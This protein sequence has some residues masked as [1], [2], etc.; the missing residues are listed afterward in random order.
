MKYYVS[1]KTDYRNCNRR[2]FTLNQQKR[3]HS[4]VYYMLRPYEKEHDVR[5]YN[6]IFQTTAFQRSLFGLGNGIMIKESGNGKLNTIRMRIPMDKFGGLYIPIAPAALQKRISDFLDQKCLEIENAKSAIQKELDVLAQY[7][8]SVVS[9]AVTK[10]L[11][12]V[13]LKAS[14]IDW[15]SQVPDNWKVIPSKY[16]FHEVNIAKYPDDERLTSSVKYGIITQE[17]YME[18]EVLPY[19]PD[20]V[21]FFEEKV[22]AK[23]PVIKVGAEIPITRYFYKYR[24][25]ATTEAL[26]AEFTEKELSIRQRVTKLFSEV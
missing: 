8:S 17:E 6:Y 1:R 10:G 3:H 14:G 2:D 5:F 9:S 26:E 4:P 12:G 22:D 21:A 19:V 7:R 25:P 16:L 15:V 24:T 20:A 18:R 11:K 13:S 23:K